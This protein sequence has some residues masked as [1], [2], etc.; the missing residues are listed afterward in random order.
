MFI[1]PLP[2]A[3][4]LN[5]ARETFLGKPRYEAMLNRFISWHN[6]RL[7]QDGFQGAAIHRQAPLFSFQVSW[8][9]TNF[10][11]TTRQKD[12]PF[13]HLNV[14]ERLDKFYYKC[15]NIMKIITSHVNSILTKSFKRVSVC[16]IT[17]RSQSPNC[18][19]LVGV[20]FY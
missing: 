8:S 7:M 15:Y 13:R 5:L 17:R 1:F 9:E 2:T 20:L 10:K 16:M 4:T 14:T 6:P 18:L 12:K 19:C 3:K 11:P